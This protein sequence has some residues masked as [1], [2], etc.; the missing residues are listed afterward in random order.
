MVDGEKSNVEYGESPKS[1]SDR[2]RSASAVPAAAFSPTTTSS[3]NL[4]ERVRRASVVRRQEMEED[5]EENGED[6]SEEDCEEDCEGYGG[7]R[8]TLLF[9]RRR[10]AGA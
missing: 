2:R 10:S 4:L 3:T 5:G 1:A 6:D 9:Q 7:V 8:F